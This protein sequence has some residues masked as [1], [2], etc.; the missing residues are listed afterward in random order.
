MDAAGGCEEHEGL[1]P[2][3]WIFGLTSLSKAFG[4]SGAT[5]TTLTE[6]SGEL[7]GG[8]T[9]GLLA[10]LPVA[11]GCS[12]AALTDLAE[13]SGELAGGGALG[14]LGEL[15]V[16]QLLNFGSPILR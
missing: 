7:A 15:P 9:L 16:G 1:A 5:L 3:I 12:A 11:F 14:L 13:A 8:G 6:E 2:V 10:E 4:C